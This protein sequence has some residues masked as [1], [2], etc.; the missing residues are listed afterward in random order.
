M[1][2]GEKLEAGGEQDLNALTGEE[3]E[4][5]IWLPEHDQEGRQWGAGPQEG[6]EGRPRTRRCQQPPFLSEG[7][8]P[9]WG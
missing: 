3:A 8:E 4:L 7:C 5:G 6:W 1:G 2:G 9:A